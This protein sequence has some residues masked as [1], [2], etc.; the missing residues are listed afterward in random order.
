MRNSESNQTPADEEIDLLA[1]AAQLW[2]A[3]KQIAQ[4]AGAITLIGLLYAFLTP[5]IYTAQVVL[6]PPQQ[7]Q[8]AASAVL[9]QL[10]GLAGGAGAAL[11]LKNPNDI[12]VS[13]I[14]SRT[15]AER[16]I[17]QFDLAKLYEVDNI[18][19]A[20]LAL[21]QVTEV[22]S[23]KDALITIKV[24]DFD[25]NRAAALA[26]AYVAAFR[27]VSGKLAMSN[28]AQRRLFYQQQLA[29]TRKSLS[30]A[31]EKLTEVQRK[32]GIL[33]LEAQGSVTI[34]AIAALRAEIAARTVALAAMREGMTPSNPELQRSQAAL[35]GLEKQLAEM[36]GKQGSADEA[37]LSRSAAPAAG[38]EYVRALREVKYNELLLE[39]LA[40]QFEIAR[41][42]EANEGSVIQ[43]LDKATPP[44]NKSKPKRALVIVL[45][46]VF[47]LV[48]GIG[49]VLARNV[50]RRSRQPLV[51]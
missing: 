40:K 32:T 37:F 42:D 2:L 29:D 35:S 21:E 45:F 20:V 10:G 16:L 33:Q 27:E 49:Y 13:V 8:S 22:A 6:M 43:V 12:Y 5:K 30:L 11:G 48:C 26:N 23:G 24:D 39:M 7:Q 51:G 3:R 19:D 34:Q 50:Y 36:L 28:A 38:K 18:D 25:P 47:G 1:V 31:E 46:A 41:L 9:A 44:F 15:V 14:K 4:I 17:Q